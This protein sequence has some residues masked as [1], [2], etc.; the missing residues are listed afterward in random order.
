MFLFRKKTKAVQN[1][2]DRE[3]IDR[4]SKNIDALLVLCTEEEHT[5]KLTKI[6]ETLKYLLPS[7]KAEVQSYDKKI[8]GQIEDLKIALT[9]GNSAKINSMIQD[10]EILIAERNALL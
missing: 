8:K 5:Q 1:T 10:L 7:T 3:M 6:K 9:K 2:N 4:S